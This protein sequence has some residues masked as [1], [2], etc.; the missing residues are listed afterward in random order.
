MTPPPIDL[1]QLSLDEVADQLVRIDATRALLELA[2]AEDLGSSG[3]VTSTALYG[4]EQAG[5]TPSSDCIVR[6]VAR[7]A[8]I[9]AGLPLIAMVADAFGMPAAVNLQSADGS[10][11]A[12]GQTLAT[13]AGPGLALLTVER[14]MLNLVGR[15]SGIATM[16]RTYVDAVQG[17]GAV[18]CETRKTTPGLR[19]LEKYATR[20]G[21]AHLHRL[22]LYD[23]VLIK[24][25]HLAALESGPLEETLRPA[26]ERAAASG[27]HRFVMVEVDTLSQFE[28]LLCL[29]SDL[30]DIVL[31]DNM[32]TQELRDAVGM[33]DQHQPKWKLEA[34][35]GITLETIRA[36]A[37]CGVDRISVGAI[38]HS[39]RCLD[40]G[41]DAG[42]GT[43]GTPE[44]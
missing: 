2:R 17:T 27:P 43:A 29:P 40:V 21:G 1:N 10:P 7:E 19:G 22:G 31:L 32:S 3:D 26:L 38:T 4:D 37:E 24:D 36:V 25:N 12:P 11:C 44:D 14:T 20:C 30:I 23:A 39:V 6:V 35:G 18:I 41:L 8:G 28:S 16:T 42:P 33:R 13:L 15:M 9:V 5:G 34:S